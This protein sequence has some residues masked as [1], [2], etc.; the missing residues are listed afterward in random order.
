MNKK[1]LDELFRDTLS[2]FKEAPND[3]VWASIEASL[4]KKKK[5]RVLP[6]WWSL[7]GVAAA[8]L[9]GFLIFNPFNKYSLNYWVFNYIN[10]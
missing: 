8:L 2:D 10:N 1:K 7:S 5:K 6:L 9:V 4:D 3:S